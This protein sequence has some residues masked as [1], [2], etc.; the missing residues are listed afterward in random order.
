MTD[1]FANS[2]APR[3]YFDYIAPILLPYFKELF[4]SAF[5]INENR[6]DLNSIKLD[7]YRFNQYYTGEYMGWHRHPGTS[8]HAIYYVELANDSPGTEL[9]VP[10]TGE[11]IRPPVREGDLMLNPSAYLHRSPANGSSERK[12]IIVFNFL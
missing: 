6:Y 10:F 2:G 1:W 8:W 9:L 7:N 11:V 3:K 4:D 12:T 5:N